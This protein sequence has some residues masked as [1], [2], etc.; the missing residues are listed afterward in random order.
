LLIYRYFQ[1]IIL[2]FYALSLISCSPT[3]HVRGNFLD[4]DEVK[5]I[6]LNKTNKVAVQELL[7]PPSSQELFGGDVW[8]YV[9]DKVEAKAFFKPEVLERT[10]LAVT[11]GPDGTVSSYELKDLTSHYDVD[12]KSESTPVKGRDPSL[13]SELFGNIG[14]YSA[15]KKTATR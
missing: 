13:V 8:Y 5:K 7:G 14:R 6:E 2:V 10:L 4:L 9:G 12:L 1:R 15:P 3:Q 11:F